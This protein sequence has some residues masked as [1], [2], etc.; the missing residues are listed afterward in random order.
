[1]KTLKLF[2]MQSLFALVCLFANGTTAIAEISIS[3]FAMEMRVA[4]DGSVIV[5]ESIVVQTDPAK[6][7]TGITRNL[8]KRWL[9]PDE[10]LIL[11]SPPQLSFLFRNGETEPYSTSETDDMVSVYFGA[12]GRQVPQ[13]LQR[14]SL[15]YSLAKLLQST[16]T[17][18]R[19][20]YL[21]PDQWSLS[22]HTISTVLVLPTGAPVS[23]VDALVQEYNFTDG[24]TDQGKLLA[25]PA[26]GAGQFSIS[27]PPSKIGKSYIVNWKF[28]KLN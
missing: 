3:D 15:Q 23:Q 16:E 18:T 20:R 27:L 21:I 26:T 11:Y 22:I 6:A 19:L 8:P 12:K 1:M 2:L 24:K 9:S 7:Y 10:K 5:T 17:E 28:P 13:G 4:R 25:V 14:Y